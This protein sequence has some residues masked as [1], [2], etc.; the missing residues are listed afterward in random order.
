[1]PE[2]EWDSPSASQYDKTRH[3]Y[4]R[5]IWPTQNFINHD[6]LRAVKDKDNVADGRYEGSDDGA[7]PES[8]FKL[9]LSPSILALMEPD[10]LSQ[11]R[12]YKPGP[13]SEGCWLQACPP[14]VK[15][16]TRLL[17]RGAS[18]GAS[19]QCV[20]RPVQSDEAADA[21]DYPDQ[22]HK[23]IDKPEAE[24]T[25][26]SLAWLLLTSACLSQGMYSIMTFVMGL[27]SCLM[28]YYTSS[29]I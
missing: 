8:E 3:D 4:W 29:L 11:M 9:F 12:T 2:A 14:H 16:Y 19:A 18:R 24:C 6:C 20:G 1:M 21:T 13:V 10:I 22:E 15:T 26:T 25:C 23:L 5:L 7:A 27:I 28:S 17:P